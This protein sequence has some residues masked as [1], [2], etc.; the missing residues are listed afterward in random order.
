MSDKGLEAL[1]TLKELRELRLGCSS[2]GVGSEGT[3]FATV[4]TMNVTEA[5]LEQLRSLTKLQRL[6]LQGCIASMT[7]RLHCWRAFRR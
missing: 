1:L 2:I 4:S 7:M 5:W 3:R 6:H